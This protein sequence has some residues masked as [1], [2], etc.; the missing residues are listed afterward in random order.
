MNCVVPCQKNN[1][2]RVRNVTMKDDDKLLV[3]TLK[4]WRNIK[5]NNHP[6]ENVTLHIVR[7]VST[8]VRFI[9]VI[10]EILISRYNFYYGGYT[11]VDL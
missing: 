7:K 10:S 4:V 8:F 3:Y 9:H 5:H 1:G 6:K 11:V 2:T